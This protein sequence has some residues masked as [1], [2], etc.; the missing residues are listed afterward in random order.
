MKNLVLCV[1]DDRTVLEGLRIHIRKS[2]GPDY[3]LEAAESGEE[4]LEVLADLAPG[5]RQFPLIICDQIMPGIK[6]DEVFVNIHARYPH[7]TKIL[8]TGQADAASVGNAL[9]RGGLYRYMAK[10]WERDDIEMTIQQGLER[11]F[12]HWNL[13]DA[14]Q[15]LLRNRDAFYR[16]VPRQFLSS[17]G[18]SEN[19]YSNL[20]QGM[21]QN[22]DFSVMFLDIRGFTTLCQKIPQAEVF[23]FLNEFF[24]RIGLE[25]TGHGGFVDKYIGD[26]VMAIF[27]DP[28]AALAAARSILAELR[29]INQ[30]RAAAGKDPVNIGI[31]ID[32]GALLLGTL[33]DDSRLQTTVLGN[34]VNTAA[35]LEELTKQY[36]LPV[37]ISAA[38]HD[39]ARDRTGFESLGEVTIRGQMNVSTLYGLKKTGK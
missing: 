39:K 13:L 17:L 4:A 23:S 1:D 10:P 34:C 38:V 31:G 24:H 20:Q 25:I 26:A 5:E 6:G 16:F 22:R 7:T 28:D 9:N 8:L 21:S 37:V 36:D 18:I 12:Q 33:G 27:P 3:Q 19:D 32:H 11:F 15:Q 29:L 14:H 35:R 2:L 30:E